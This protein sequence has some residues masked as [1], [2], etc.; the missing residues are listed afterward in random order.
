MLFEACRVGGKS[1]LGGDFVRGIT[2][3]FQWQINREE[4]LSG[5]LAG[6]ALVPVCCLHRGMKSLRQEWVKSVNLQMQQTA[7][8]GKERQQEMG[9]EQNKICSYFKQ[10]M[11][12][13]FL[14]RKKE[15]LSVRKGRLN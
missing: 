11:F 4:F 7:G 14:K 1:I 8:N 12:F 9:C 15:I 2:L 13:C 5:F 6:S 3:Q 10:E